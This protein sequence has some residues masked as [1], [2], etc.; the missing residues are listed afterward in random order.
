VTALCWLWHRWSPWSE[1][2]KVTVRHPRKDVWVMGPATTTATTYTETYWRQRRTCLR[3]NAA[4]FREV[5][6]ER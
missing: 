5:P 2:E 6:N 1:P 3:C 4:E